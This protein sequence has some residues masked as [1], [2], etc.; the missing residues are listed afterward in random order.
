MK[1]YAPVLAALGTAFLIYGALVASAAPAR[2]WTVAV[3]LD[4][5]HN[6]DSSALDDLLEMTQAGP[7]KNVNVVYQLDRKDD[8][9][10]AGPGVERGVIE[11][12]KRV[13]VE[14]LPELNSDDP[15]NVAAFLNWA[16]DSYPSAR[17]GLIMWDHGGQW[18]GGF[19]GDTHG[20]GLS[21]ENSGNLKP[22]AFAAALQGVLKTL[23]GQPLDFLGFDTCLMGG[24]EL[25]AQFAPLTR[26]YIAD[27]EIDY[28]NGWN[29]A[30]TLRVLDAT[31]E[32]SMTDFGA[33]EVRLWEAQ[34]RED[35]SDKLYGVH[36]AYDTSRWPE[37][38][39]QLDALS[40]T[41]TPLIGAPGTAGFLWRARGEAFQYSF[42]NEG[43]PG[44]TLPY[45]DLG[46]FAAKV[47]QYSGDAD[48]KAKA[49]ALGAATDQLVIAKSLGSR[50]NGASALSIYY[51][52]QKQTVP[53]AELLTRYKALSM[54]TVSPNTAGAWA[55]F[56]QTWTEAVRADTTPPGLKNADLTPNKDSGALVSFTAEG[57]DVYSAL[58]S[59]YQALG[60]GQ[61]LDYGDVYYKRITA[62]DYRFDWKTQA[63]SVGDGEVS[64]LITADRG[65]PDDEFMSASAQYTPPGSEPYDV[66]VQFSGDGEVT[67]LLDDSGESPIGMDAEE[68]AALQFYL[69]TYDETTEEYGWQLQKEKLDVTADDLSNLMA[70]QSELP[71]GT[72]ELDFSVSDYAGNTA[73]DNLEIDVR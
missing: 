22:E 37:V 49:A 30:P 44:K 59:L 48:V 61:Y 23:G 12:G 42:D 53:D 38:Q 45:I 11:N 46:H 57:A 62:G 32:I 69:R 70:E 20:P 9:E 18:D 8:E 27:A 25:I 52:T 72:F 36:A 50:R 56:Q 29:Y 58:V 35:A 41:L 63:W 55:N 17:R 65:D 21:E 5:D 73:G 3:Y 47:S 2:P 28:G 4:A 54:N 67:G 24:A 7:L 40:V 33:Q 66:I 64:S 68:G 51:P 10:G 39:K 1:L 13:E 60:K 34:H 71:D 31:P 6:L 43:Q 19:G 14:T 26:L 16:Y 15:Q